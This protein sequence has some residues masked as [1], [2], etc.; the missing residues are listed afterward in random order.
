MSKWKR[1]VSAIQAILVVLCCLLF[2]SLA[3]GAQRYYVTPNGT[4]NG[5]SWADA[6]GE[7]GFRNELVTAG[8]GDEFWVAAGKYRPSDTDRIVSFSLKSGVSLYGGFAGNETE[9]SQRDWSANITVL[10][11]DLD[12]NDTTDAHGVTLTAD[13]INSAGKGNSFNVIDLVN[14]SNTVVLDGFVVSGGMPSIRSHGN[15]S[16]DGAGGR[17]VCREQ[18]YGDPELLIYRKFCLVKWRRD[19][20]VPLWFPGDKLLFLGKYIVRGRR[21]AY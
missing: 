9:L 13:D 4:G 16:V 21:N 19:F 2:V 12:F 15:R 8:D 11:G 1:R 20:C 3:D 14:V 7:S 10:T 17:Y 5:S 18:R 6:L